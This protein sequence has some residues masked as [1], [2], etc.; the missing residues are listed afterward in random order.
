MSIITIL[1]L[2]L[3]LSKFTYTKDASDNI[4]Y[5]RRFYIE[6]DIIGTGNSFKDAAY[7]SICQSL[8]CTCCIG[9]LNEMRCGVKVL[10]QAMKDAGS[11]QKQQSLMLLVIFIIALYI[12]G[13][14][15]MAVSIYILR[16]Q[17]LCFMKAIVGYICFTFGFIFLFPFSIVILLRCFSNKRVSIKP[18][19]A[20]QPE[21]K[22]I[23]FNEFNKEEN[24]KST[25]YLNQFVIKTRKLNSVD[26]TDHSQNVVINIIGGKKQVDDMEILNINLNKYYLN[27]NVSPKRESK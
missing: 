12:L 11:S 2:L 7:R 27:R 8:G 17:E 3:Q 24:E 5:I 1:Y 22:E 16:K 6:N 20:V 13:I 23:V 26:K 25:S 19:K 21:V 9:E 10:C 14:T 15:F 18:C 4:F